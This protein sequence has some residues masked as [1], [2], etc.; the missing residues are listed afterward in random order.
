MG[1]VYRATDIQTGGLVAVRVLDPRVV[2]PAPGLL[3]R[4]V[5]EGE[6]LRQLKHPNIV[7][8]VAAV[9]EEGATTGVVAHYLV[10]EYGRG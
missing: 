5:R 9:E 10:M 3:E 2:A 6:A 4:F 7:R 1:E 8:M